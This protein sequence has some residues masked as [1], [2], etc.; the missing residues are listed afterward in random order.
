[1]HLYI[2]AGRINVDVLDVTLVDGFKPSV[3]GYRLSVIDFEPAIWFKVL[4]LDAVRIDCDERRLSWVP[5]CDSSVSNFAAVNSGIASCGSYQFSGSSISN[6]QHHLVDSSD[7]TPGCQLSEAFDVIPDLLAHYESNQ[8]TREDFNEQIMQLLH[9]HVLPGIKLTAHDTDFIVACIKTLEDIIDKIDRDILEVAEKIRLAEQ[10][11]TSLRKKMLNQ[12]MSRDRVANPGTVLSHEFIDLLLSKRGIENDIKI[13]WDAVEHVQVT[14]E[15]LKQNPEGSDVALR[16][17]RAE[18]DRVIAEYEKLLIVREKLKEMRRSRPGLVKRVR[19][20]FSSVN[21]DPQQNIYVGIISKLE[22]FE[23]LN[24]LITQKKLLVTSVKEAAR[25]ALNDVLSGSDSFGME[26]DCVGAAHSTD[27]L[28]GNI[29]APWQSL[30]EQIASILGSS[31]HPIAKL[32]RD[33]CYHIKDICSATAVEKQLQDVQLWSLQSLHCNSCC[34]STL[35]STTQKSLTHSSSSGSMSE[36]QPELS[37]TACQTSDCASL[38]V[39]QSDSRLSK[40][41]ELYKPGDNSQQGCLMRSLPVLQTQPAE[42]SSNSAFIGNAQKFDKKF[43]TNSWSHRKAKSSLLKSSTFTSYVDVSPGL[44]S[45]SQNNSDRDSPVIIVDTERDCVRKALESIREE[46]LGHFDRISTQLQHEL[47]ASSGRAQYQQVWLDYE[48][49]F[50]QEMMSPLTQLYH[51]KYASIT[52][53]FCSCLLELTP[54]DLRLDDAVLIHLLQNPQE[55]TFESN[56]PPVWRSN[57]SSGIENTSHSD[58][59]SKGL[60]PPHARMSVSVVNEGHIDGSIEEADD[61]SRLLRSHSEETKSSRLRTR[62]ISMKVNV[63]PHSPESVLIYERTLAP[64][65]FERSSLQSNTRLTLSAT[66]MKLKPYYR[67]QFASALRF[68][69]SAVEARTPGSKLRHLTDCLRETTKQLTAFYAELY[70]DSSSQSSC[71]ELLDAVVILLCNID[72]RQMS[73]L[74]CQLTLLADLMAPWLVR[75]PQSFTLVQFTGACQ[76]IQERLMWKRNAAYRS[77]R[78]V[79]CDT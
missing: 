40:S 58:T 63:V 65:P 13:A 44:I 66:T 19:D 22:D 21:E 8:L 34:S 78:V 56:T 29:R 18:R 28:G 37:N 15:K 60:G 72:G 32:H 76:F 4:V 59:Q 9:V 14:V 67:Q 69:E 23:K 3:G 30:A 53:A 70:G 5:L 61:L 64:L 10:S 57:G 51:L 20:A 24:Q 1:M 17:K 11:L 38:P 7:D 6:D 47:A 39:E 12:L 73:V 54:S 55:E 79:V 77:R 31:S 35:K 25:L 45:I 16:S 46:I 41:M 48:N 36:C 74:Y 62:R 49:H 42:S 68:I 50:Y 26:V 43:C 52:D 71:D 27:V 2:V 33:F 75:G